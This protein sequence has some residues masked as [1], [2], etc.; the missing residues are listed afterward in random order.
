MCHKNVF[1]LN[2]FMCSMKYECL[3]KKELKP[4]F[5]QIAKMN[6]IPYSCRAYQLST[7]H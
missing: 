5:L 3:V 7:K 6:L 4:S 1:T 2:M